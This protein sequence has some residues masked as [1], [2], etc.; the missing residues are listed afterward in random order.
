MAHIPNFAAYFA[1]AIGVVVAIVVSFSAV[2]RSRG[3]DA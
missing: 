3:P 2:R 1:I